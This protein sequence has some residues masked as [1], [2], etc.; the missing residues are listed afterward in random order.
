MS[1]FAVAVAVTQS[2]EQSPSRETSSSSVGKDV[3][4]LVWNHKLCHNI[5]KSY[6]MA[7]ILS[8]M[9]PA[10]LFLYGPF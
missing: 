9:N 2:I 10:N 1:S 4:S 3:P 6:P 7:F 8:H 5:C